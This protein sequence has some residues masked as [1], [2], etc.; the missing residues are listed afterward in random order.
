MR[1]PLSEPRSQGSPHRLAVNRIWF[2]MTL[3]RLAQGVR[4]MCN[5]GA[6]P[7]L[8]VQY[9]IQRRSG[10][11]P[12][13]ILIWVLNRD[14]LKA[15]VFTGRGQ[16]NVAVKISAIAESEVLTRRK[17]QLNTP[18]LSLS[19]PLVGSNTDIDEN[20]A[21]G[22]LNNLSPWRPVRNISLRACREV[23]QGQ[24]VRAFA[25]RN[26]VPQRNG[27]A[28]CQ[29]EHGALLVAQRLSQW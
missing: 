27:S 12:A 21:D 3:Q 15:E 23:L 22:G 1:W 14:L 29:A 20:L 5:L 19:H 11:Q 2:T 4:P 6:A 24:C 16:F 10:M 7:H 13:K 17:G 9:E 18:A 25:H 26:P 8:I 28:R